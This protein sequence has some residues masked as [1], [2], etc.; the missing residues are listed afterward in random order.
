M[1]QQQ[2]ATGNSKPIFQFQPTPQTE[3]KKQK[4]SPNQAE[5]GQSSGNGLKDLSKLLGQKAGESINL[6]TAS[7]NIKTEAN[8]TSVSGELEK[9]PA[10]MSNNKKPRN[11]NNGGNRYNRNRNNYNNRNTKKPQQS[12]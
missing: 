9:R 1:Q 8:D 2:V 11:N 5:G 10:I 3:F 6:T 7:P 4:I 12:K